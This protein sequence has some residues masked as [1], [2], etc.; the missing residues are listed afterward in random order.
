MCPNVMI[1]INQ[2]SFSVCYAHEI[3]GTQTLPPYAINAMKHFFC[4]MQHQIYLFLL[5]VKSV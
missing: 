4:P 2:V 3:D 5:F 1:N